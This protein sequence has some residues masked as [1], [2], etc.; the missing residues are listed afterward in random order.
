MPKVSEQHLEARRQQ[1]V[2]AAFQCFARKGFHPTTMQDICAEAELSA[3]AIY[4][5]FASKEEIISTAC[6]ESQH[7]AEMDLLSAA[8]GETDSTAM[9]KGLAQAFFSGFDGPEGDIGNRAMVQL[10]AELA[11]NED[12]RVNHD[13]TY[14][15]MREGL[16]DVVRE[17]Q[18]RGDY[19]TDLDSEAI[20]SAMIALHHGFQL[21]KAIHP[22]LGTEAY[23]KVVEALL[24][25]TLW[26]GDIRT[27]RVDP[28]RGA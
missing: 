16:N 15:R 12:L 25:G 20:V 1:I 14:M 6:G 17:T 11:V 10:W 8:I 26:T 28:T 2:D 7:A 19:S 4:R 27:G 13:G 9:F 23:E 18:R 22:A 21:Q 5:Y 24:T 3:G